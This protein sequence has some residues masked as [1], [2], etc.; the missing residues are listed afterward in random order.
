[1][2]LSLIPLVLVTV[3][4]GVLPLRA[5]DTSSQT[6]SSCGGTIELNISAEAHGLSRE[7]VT[8]WVKRAADAVCTYYGR[9]PVSRVVLNVQVREGEGVRHGVTYPHQGGGLIRISVGASTPSSDLDQDWMLTHEMIHLAFP[10]MSEQHHWIEEG[11][12][13]YVEPI[14]RVQA[15]QL[16]GAKMWSDVIRDM[17][18]GEPQ[19]GDEGLDHS[20]LP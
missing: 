18:Q 20:F 10:Y 2:R 12:S 11:I 15:G 3:I 4:A 14:A 1:M 16:A 8:T 17:P 5:A 7:I 6:L 19:S 13:V 9:Y